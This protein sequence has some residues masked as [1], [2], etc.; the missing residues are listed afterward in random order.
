M[1]LEPGQHSAQLAPA[2]ELESFGFTGTASGYF[3]IWI[4]NLCL[5]VL[6]IG[7]Y[8]AWAKVRRNKYLY[9]NTRLAGGNFDY[10]AEPVPI[11]KGRLIAVAL[12]AL[13][14]GSAFILPGSDALVFLLLMA[15]LPWLLVRSRMFAMRNTS[16][17]NIRFSF[18]PVYQQ[19]YKVIIGYYL[20]G[21]LTLGLALPWARFW[22]ARLLAD[23]TRFGRLNVA[24]N[25]EVTAGSFYRAYFAVSLA[26]LAVFSVAGLL[27]VPAIVTFMA[28]DTPDANTAPVNFQRLLPLLLL[29]GPLYLLPVYALEAAITRLTLNQLRIGEHCLKCRWSVMKLVG[30]QVTN[31][32][33]ILLSLGLLIP[34]ATIR[35]QRYK[36]QNLALQPAGDL[37]TILAGSAPEVS[38]LGEEIGEAFDFDF[39]L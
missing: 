27:L 31:L 33:A 18:S 7:I 13:Y 6:T 8:S 24:M 25:S 17:R 2:S 29:V 30:I 38:P 21:L 35:V 11:L 14:L 12:L 1:P 28:G 19:A 23:N 20:V 34:W 36:L 15:V 9:R 37:D 39:G 22:R 32:Y 16:Y 5:T 4:V 10:H 3:R 26:T